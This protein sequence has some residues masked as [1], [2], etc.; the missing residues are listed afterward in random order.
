M[1]TL[2]PSDTTY[3]FLVRHGATDANL[4]QPYILQGQ[5]INGP[6]SKLG[7]R[8]AA[9]CSALLSEFP[10][11]Q[12]YASPMLR[13][14]ES[15]AAIA[16]PHQLP[17]QTAGDINE[18]DVGRWEGM[19]WG[20]IERDFAEAYAYFRENPAKHGYLEG[21]SYGDVAAR[22]TPVLNGLLEKHRGESIV[23]VA[24]NVVNR[25]YLAT[26]LGV[27]LELAP[28]IRQANCGVNIIRHNPQETV[29]TTMNAAFH[30]DGLTVG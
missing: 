27:P 10:L 23:V 15:A 17:V 16:K 3:L 24:H 7:V 14:Q 29:V 6:L 13:A 11:S 26:L 8:Q 28:T 19:D 20:S 12:V 2:P 25:V 5:G 21:E 4:Q 18:C 22:V 30:L 1:K 9:A